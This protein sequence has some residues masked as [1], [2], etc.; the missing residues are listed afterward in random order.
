MKVVAI[1]GGFDPVHKGHIRL[2][3]EAARLGGKL[4]IILNND[5]WL[6]KKKGFAFMAEDERAEVL[7]AIRGIDEVII[8]SHLFVKKWKILNQ[9]STLTVAIVL[10]MT[11]Q[12]LNFVIIWES[13]WCSMWEEKRLKAQAGWLKRFKTPVNVG[14]TQNFLQYYHPKPREGDCSS[15]RAFFSCAPDPPLR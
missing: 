1:A 2:I 3:Q 10:L 13:K 5:N 11:F 8:T 15:P 4:V 12:S 7:R 9:T 14:P 6:K